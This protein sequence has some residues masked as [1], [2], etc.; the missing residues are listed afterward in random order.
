VSEPRLHLVP[1]P[2]VL[3]HAVSSC[4]RARGDKDL[5]PDWDGPAPLCPKRP[6]LAGE[7]VDTAFLHHGRGRACFFSFG[8]GMRVTA[9]AGHPCPEPSPSR[10]FQRRGRP[11]RATGLLYCCTPVAAPVRRRCHYPSSIQC[12][13]SSSTTSSFSP[14]VDA[15]SPRRSKPTSPSP[16]KRCRCASILF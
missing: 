10:C 12:P 4:R 6:R 3:L 13:A 9:G 1:R 15:K 11:P 5:R 2:C 14:D 16:G 8:S 7:F